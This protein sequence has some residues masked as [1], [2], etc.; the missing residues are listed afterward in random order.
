M[1]GLNQ[2]ER[3]PD[4]NETLGVEMCVILRPGVP[5]IGVVI[6]TK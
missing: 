4:V 1:V 5:F 2:A 3:W 6:A